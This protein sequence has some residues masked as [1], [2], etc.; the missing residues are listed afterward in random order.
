MNP[1]FKGWDW[2]ELAEYWGIDMNQDEEQIAKDME[3][4][5]GNAMEEVWDKKSSQITQDVR[6]YLKVLS[7][8][9]TYE[10]PVW[11]GLLEVEHDLILLNFTMTLFR[12]MW[13]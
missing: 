12:N 8:Y 7:E 11:K 10:Q 2:C 13:C 4:V 3:E 5:I 6:N 1:I 9:N